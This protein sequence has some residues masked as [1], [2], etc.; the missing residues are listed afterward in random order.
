M[1]SLP[2]RGVIYAV[3]PHQYC[4]HSLAL[5]RIGVDWAAA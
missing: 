4:G 5:D 2:R 1:R 3:E